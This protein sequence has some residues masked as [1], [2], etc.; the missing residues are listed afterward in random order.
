[1]IHH[2]YQYSKQ[3]FVRRSLH[4]FF[5]VKYVGDIS[6][7]IWWQNIFGNDVVEI[8]KQKKNQLERWAKDLLFRQDHAKISSNS[9]QESNKT[10]KGSSECR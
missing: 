7:L 2:T 9:A 1:M 10:H 6:P 3:E 4:S 5:L 8:R